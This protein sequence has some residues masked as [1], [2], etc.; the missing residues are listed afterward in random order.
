MKNYLI[1]TIMF[2]I[3]LSSAGSFANDLLIDSSEK[4]SQA[5]KNQASKKYNAIIIENIEK[6]DESCL[7]NLSLILSNNAEL[8]QILI[9][10]CTF[11]SNENFSFLNGIS[12]GNL[13]IV[14]CGLTDAN[15][16]DVL[17][18]LYPYTIR[19]LDFSN[20]KFGENG[21]LFLQTLADN[22]GLKFGVEELIISNN[23]FNT[24][25]TSHLE[26]QKPQGIK[27]LII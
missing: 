20:N 15:L 7:E 6:F 2:L 26:T 21:N 9:S 4:L 12:I 19:K 25:I 17:R 8:T 27:K 14:N 10:R 23:H 11:S 18:N 13:S 22:F 5:A 24:Q 3:K 16:A 1:L